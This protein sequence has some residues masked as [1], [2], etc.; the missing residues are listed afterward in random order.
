VEVAVVIEADVVE[1]TEAVEVEVMGEIEVLELEVM[2]AAMVAEIEEEAVE[3]AVAVVLLKRSES[4][5]KSFSVSPSIS[6]CL[7]VQIPWS[8]F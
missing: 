1:V 4:S 3:E 2:E 6:I 8:C 5:G 7:A